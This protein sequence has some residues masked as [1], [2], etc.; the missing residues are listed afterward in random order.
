MAGLIQAYQQTVLDN[1]VLFPTSAAT[2]HIAYST[3]GT[4]ESVAVI[5]A[6]TP[7]GAAGWAAATAATPS[8]KAN[9][10][11]LTSA[12]AVGA[13]TITHFAL[14]SAVTAGTQKTDWTALASP[15]TLGVG[16]TIQ[17]AIGALQVTLD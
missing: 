8:V 13:G 9:N 6:R 10:A 17:W 15:R 14:F 16:D 12:T 2:D 7:V 1:A 11:I 3:N 5:A 4:T